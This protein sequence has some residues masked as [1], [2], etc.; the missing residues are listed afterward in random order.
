MSKSVSG[1]FDTD[2]NTISIAIVP[3]MESMQEFHIQSSPASAE[4]LRAAGGVNDLVTKSELLA[5]RFMITE[6][7]HI[8][9]RSE[10]FSAF[11]HPNWGM[12]GTFAYFSPFF[13]NIL[14]SGPP[15]HIQLALRFEF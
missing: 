6:Q 12:P 15:R 4:F 3:P 9:F 14:A 2:R 7:S 5:R 8:E 1:A 10:F 13:G 11:N